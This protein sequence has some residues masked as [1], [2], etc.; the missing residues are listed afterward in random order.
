MAALTFSLNEKRMALRRHMMNEDPETFGKSLFE[1]EAHR[2]LNTHNQFNTCRLYERTQYFGIID[3]SEVLEEAGGNA[4]HAGIFY[5]M[6]RADGLLNYEAILLTYA[7]SKDKH[8]ASV[9]TTAI[10]NCASMYGIHPDVLCN[11]AQKYTFKKF[12][13][14]AESITCMVEKGTGKPAKAIIPFIHACPDVSNFLL[15]QQ[16]FRM[17]AD[18]MHDSFSPLRSLSECNYKMNTEPGFTVNEAA[19]AKADA[20]EDEYKEEVKKAK[21]REDGLIHEVSAAT[22]LFENTDDRSGTEEILSSEDE[23]TY[24]V[25]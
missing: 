17:G 8:F 5:D 9:G 2:K 4:V 21:L 22:S 18:E 20:Y 16:R 24:E 13:D 19:K 25:V 12:I 11:L 23:G 6:A 3:P 10:G 1:L 14:E 7:M 15:K